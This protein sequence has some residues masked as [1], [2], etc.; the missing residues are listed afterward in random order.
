MNDWS[1]QG[2]RAVQYC[3]FWRTYFNEQSV[4]KKYKLG[5]K[6]VKFKSEIVAIRLKKWHFD[7]YKLLWD[8]FNNI[9]CKIKRLQR[10]TQTDVYV[11]KILDLTHLLNTNSKINWFVFLKFMCY[12]INQM[13]MPI[14]TLSYWSGG[15]I[16][17]ALY[18][19]D[20]TSPNNLIMYNLNS[21][22][23]WN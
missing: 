9:F 3:I 5:V 19:I 13:V 1:L 11:T 6:C 21:F 16:C 17:N 2:N 23:L 15:K 12:I 10:Y 8:Y 18:I 4:S 14:F 22:E 7:A 20:K